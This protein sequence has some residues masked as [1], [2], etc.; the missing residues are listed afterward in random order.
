MKHIFI[1]LFVL[2]I[3]V[4]A[5]SSDEG[6]T[7]KTKAK[8]ELQKAPGEKENPPFKQFKKKKD[9]F[10]DKDGDGICDNRAKGMSFEKSRK[11]F[12]FGKHGNGNKGGGG[13]K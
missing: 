7:T 4:P 8:K 11:R 10:I 1:I 6:D 2:M 12:R 5:Y 3:S 9:V 13:R